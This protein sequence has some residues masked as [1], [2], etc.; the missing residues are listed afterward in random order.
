MYE[1]YEKHADRY[2][3]LVMAEDLEGN[4]YRALHEL[5]DWHG[6]S[7]F[8]A[9][10]G[11]GRVT[12]TYIHQADSAYCCDR[13]EHM[14][15][16][17]KDNLKK[18]T[19]KI[20]FAI[21]EN[22][23]LPELDRAFDVFIEGWSFGHATSDCTSKE[24]IIA[25]TSLLVGSA[26]KNIKPGGVIILIESLGTN[27]ELP[28]PP[29]KRLDIFYTALTDLHGFRCSKIKTDYL[30]DSNA[31]AVR[32]MGFFFGEDIEQSIRRRGSR[33]V[34]EWTGIW[35]KELP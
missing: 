35:T 2:H 30:F 21:A 14:L 5:A 13:S 7:V 26:E 16:F 32:V 33:I 29:N 15:A 22:S 25:R 3:E 8:E 24:E 20:E 4:L 31:E 10:V 18:Y 6:L 19:S 12:S 11:T 23:D 34:P 9:G 28:S 27:V 17:A 1:I